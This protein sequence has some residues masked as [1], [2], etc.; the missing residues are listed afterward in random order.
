MC[1]FLR[2]DDPKLTDILNAVTGWGLDAAELADIGELSLSL[3]RLFNIREG[4]GAA[5]DKLPE[6]VMK[7]HVS[8]VLSRVRLDAGDV[9]EQVR[10]YYR[11]RGW[12]DD[13]VP[14]PETLERL[15]IGEYAR[16]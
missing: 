7:P 15:G 4:F 1:F 3:A 16:S 13:G 14:T 5:D 8:G 6:Q 12:S 10:S 2:Y 11:S 9:A